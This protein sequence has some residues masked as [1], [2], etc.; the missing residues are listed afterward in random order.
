MRSFGPGACLVFCVFLGETQF[1][2]L[3]LFKIWSIFSSLRVWLTLTRVDLGAHPQHLPGFSL[4]GL[5][6]LPQDLLVLLVTSRLASPSH[7]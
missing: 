1:L 5:P 6:G 7:S 4:L 2:P 3:E